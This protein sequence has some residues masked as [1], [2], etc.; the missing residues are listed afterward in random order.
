MQGPECVKRRRQR[1]VWIVTPR[2]TG[3]PN[4]FGPLVVRHGNGKPGPSGRGLS[5]RAVARSAILAAA[6]ALPVGTP[7]VAELVFGLTVALLVLPLALLVGRRD[8]GLLAASR[9]IEVPG[10][11]AE[12]LRHPPLGQRAPAGP[13]GVLLGLP[14]AVDAPLRRPRRWRQGTVCRAGGAAVSDQLAQRAAPPR[15]A[16]GGRRAAA[17]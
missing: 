9:R 5:A 11:G 10:P 12:R 16:R 7:I 15:R 6:V 17:A 4:S 2:R 13:L 8:A 3:R 1:L 14:L